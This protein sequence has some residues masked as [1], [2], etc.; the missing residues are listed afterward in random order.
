[1]GTVHTLR[2]VTYD[3]LASCPKP[4][5][6]WMSRLLTSGGENPR[7]LPVECNIRTILE[8]DPL[9]RG[10]LM[11][12]LL[13]GGRPIWAYPPA[14]FG[15]IA[16]GT[17]WEDSDDVSLQSYLSRAPYGMSPPQL[18]K[19]RASVNGARLAKWHPVR[20]YLSRL[21]W[22]GTPRVREWLHTYTG[23]TQSRSSKLVGPWWLVGAVARAFAP[24]CQVDYALILES[25]EQGLK[26]SSLVRALCPDES[27]FT[28]DVGELGSKDTAIQL[29]GKWIVELA[30]LASLQSARDWESVKKFV[31]QR[32]DNYRSP[33]GVYSKKRPRSCVFCGT[34]NRIQYLSDPTGARRFWPVR[35]TH[36]DLDRLIADRD[37][38]WAE[39]T[40]LYSDGVRY[41]PEERDKALLAEETAERE[42]TDP[43]EAALVDYCASGAPVTTRAIMTDAL[44]I[45]IGRQTRQDEM[46]VAAILRRIGYV[47]VSRRA[48]NG[49]RER[50]FSLE[51]P[52]PEPTAE[53][54]LPF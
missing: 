11:S 16:P 25:P 34:T 51:P 40:K 32:E 47:Y 33:Y 49:R 7:L 29:E 8:Q 27:W 41:W 6:G 35:I 21:T 23:A 13:H 37:Q 1:M 28:D 9:F 26:K 46:R 39:A 3:P 48:I 20:E 14:E 15:T 45:E 43:W 31:S 12:S 18:N 24:G 5:D 30:E 4:S 54:E 52:P 38:L 42:T 10:R 17:L 50:W 2:S 19:I 44:E 36:I 22:D 53:D